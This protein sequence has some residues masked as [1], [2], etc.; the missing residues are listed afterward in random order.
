[1]ATIAGL[2]GHNAFSMRNPNKVR[3]LIGVFANANPV[4]FHAVDGSG[5]AFLA[6]RIL[7]LDPLNPQVAARLLA[8]LGRWRRFDERRQ[9]SMRG[10]LERILAVPGLSRDVF[11]LA[12]KSVGT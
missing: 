9:A 6:D 5:H 2:L 4:R 7:E 12:S 11:E 10:Q 3:A 1:L 8:P